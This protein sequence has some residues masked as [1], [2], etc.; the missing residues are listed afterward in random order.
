MISCGLQCVNCDYP[1]HFDTYTGCSHKCRYC[2]KAQR[3][4]TIA[5]KMYDIK[6]LHAVK[7]VRDF[8]TGKRN[9]EIVCFDWDIPLHWGANSD[10]FQECEREYKASL[11]VLKVFA[12]TKYPFIVSTKNP[13]LLTEEPYLTLVSECECVIQISMAC[14]KYDALEPGAP[15]YEERLKAAEILSKHVTRVVARV[16]PYMI[17]CKSAIISELPRMAKAG[18]HGIIVSG[19]LSPNKHKGMTKSGKYY[20]F[21]DAIQATDYKQI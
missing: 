7:S 15:K 5:R 2:F 18:I 21:S 6:P 1:V 11:D 4:K 16:Q 10:P 20:K 17:D 12:E 3:S 19:Y 13:V 9:L 14:S 8:I